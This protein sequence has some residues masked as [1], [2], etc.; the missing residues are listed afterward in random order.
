MTKL[1]V[2]KVV[3]ERGVV[4]EFCVKIVGKRVVFDN[5]SC[6]VCVCACASLCVCVF[7]FVKVLHVKRDV[8]ERVLC[9]RAVCST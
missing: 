7:E 8:G 3:C 6:C 2:R 5:V 4:K 9:E 1:Y